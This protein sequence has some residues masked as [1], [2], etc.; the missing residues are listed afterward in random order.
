M[1]NESIGQERPHMRPPINA[2][3]I[4]ASGIYDSAYWKI[5]DEKFM[6]ED[7]EPIFP[8]EICGAPKQC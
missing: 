2:N 1:N 4:T 3:D 7:Y 8:D 5:D 6:G